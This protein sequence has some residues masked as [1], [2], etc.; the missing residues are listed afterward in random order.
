MVKKRGNGEGDVYPRKNKEGKI[1]GYRGAYWVRTAKG[2]RRCYV[3]GRNKSQTRAA[4]TKAKA[5]RDGG[6]VFESGTQTVEQYLARW[7]SDSVKDTVRPTTYA[8]YEQN[9]RR[10][11]T[12][13]LGTVKLRDLAPARI[14]TLYREKLDEGLSRR[15]VQYVH[16]TL[17][18]AL[19][20][21]AAD[22]LVPRNAAA[23]VTA[24]RPQKK[25]IHPLTPEQARALLEAARGDR[26]EALYSLAVHCGLRQGELLALKWQDVDLGAGTLQ[27]RRTLSIT[28]D[29]PTFNPPKTAKGRRRIG[30]TTAAVAALEDHL[31]RQIAEVEAL[32]DAYEDRGLVFPGKK[33]QPLS[34]WSLTGGPYPRLLERAGLPKS[35]RFH[36]LR[37]TC[38]T[39][40]LCE[41]VHPKLVQELLGH[42]TVAITLD[43]YSHVL[44]SLGDRATRA[45]ED[46]L[47]GP[48]DP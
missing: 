26:F 32:G 11:I 29:G 44:P 43:T 8:R 45:M 17:H 3:S 38:A 41:G 13:A 7:L 25:E 34:P 27:V 5:E 28:K 46:A 47:S 21:A 12:P 10:H 35:T 6:L 4:L 20:Q 24:P 39:L 14:R 30:L 23:N 40:L 1:I 18:K 19:K 2:P 33:G 16:V 48:T 36:D 15:T 22:G 42:A 9:V 31:R 37:H